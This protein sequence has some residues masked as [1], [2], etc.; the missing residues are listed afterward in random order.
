MPKGRTAPGGAAGH[1]EAGSTLNSSK[2]WEI[3]IPLQSPSKNDSQS[4]AAHD[5]FADTIPKWGLH[6]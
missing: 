5:S 4:Q 1:T 3:S 2:I 6:L